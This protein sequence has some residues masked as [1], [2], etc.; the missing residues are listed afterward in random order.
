M[1]EEWAHFVAA[2]AVLLLLGLALLAFLLT[3]AFWHLVH[4]YGS[5]IWQLIVRIWSALSGS[6][7]ATR[8][9]GIPVV[10]RLLSG[11][12]TFGRSLGLYATAA[13][14]VALAGLF[15]FFDIADEIGADEELT[16]FDAA[17]AMALRQTISVSTLRLFAAITRLGDFGF[18]VGLSTVVMA[19][20]LLRGERQL[21]AA[22]AGGTAA[23]GALNG[24]LKAI[25][26]RERP[27]FDAEVVLAAGWSFPSGHASGSVIVYG[28]LGYL[29]ILHTGRPWHGPIAALIA[30]VVVF[31]GFSRVV[32]QVHYFSDVL[33]GYAT[34]AAWVALCVAGTEAVRWRRRRQPDERA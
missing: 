11:T 5:G 19:G 15:L 18:L 33:A 27:S 10:G 14:V 28:L 30:L 21:A 29:L 8:L 1:A 32:L 2:H 7:L 34:G 16:R 26:E 31:V 17:L 22:W 9:R 23:G 20:L 6:P 25:F 13:F 4:G 24:A 3:L 12:L